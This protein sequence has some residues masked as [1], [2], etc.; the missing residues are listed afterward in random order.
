MPALAMENRKSKKID[1]QGSS[2][3]IKPD[4]GQTTR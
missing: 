1:R 2:I 3:C 4:V